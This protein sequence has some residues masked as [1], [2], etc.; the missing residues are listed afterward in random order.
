MPAFD[1]V[2]ATKGVRTRVVWLG[3]AQGSVVG[4]PH[5]RWDVV[6]IVEYPDFGSF[7]R[8]TESEEYAAEAH[9]HRSAALE[10]W[11]LIAALPMGAP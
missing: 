3:G 7:R 9:P 11:R 1:R 6:A 5:E 8:I 4:T 2:A 10:D